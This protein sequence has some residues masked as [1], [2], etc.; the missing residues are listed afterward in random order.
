M[1]KYKGLLSTDDPRAPWQWEP[2]AR[3]YRGP[4]G[5]WIGV[6]SM[7]ELKEQFI[8]A[9][10]AKM[11]KLVE[12]MA[13]GDITRR[14]WVLASR[15]VIKGTYVDLYAL[16]KGGRGAMTQSDYG[17]LG[18]MLKGQYQRLQEFEAALR[19][20]KLT[21]R[22]AAYRARLY[23]NSARQ[24]FQ[25]GYTASYGVPTLPAQPGDGSTACRANC[26]CEWKITELADAWECYWTL[27]AAEHCDD[28]R[29]RAA[30]WNPL[31]IPKSMARFRVDLDSVLTALVG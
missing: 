8:E 11:E 19:D 26:R 25:A 17:K 22:G 4:R 16:S 20:G 29:R 27:G 18:A 14:E 5:Q 10:K 12:R 15:E 30:Q 7:R 28:C 21:Q 1:G 31:R 24:A 2:R 23:I 3:R 6:N 13:N 9:Q